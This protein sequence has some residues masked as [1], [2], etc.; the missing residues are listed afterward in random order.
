MARQQIDVSPEQV[1]EASRSFVAPSELSGSR[2]RD[3]QLSVGGRF[4]YAV[5]LLLFAGAL[6]AAI[7]LSRVSAQQRET[8]QALDRTGVVTTA[9]VTRLWRRDDDSWA[10]YRFET[11]GVEYERRTKMRS[12]RWRALH[13]G[14]PIDVRYLP[15]HPQT[16]VLAGSEPGALP[17]FVPFLLAAML[18]AGG[19]LILWAINCQRRLLSDGRAAAA[20]VTDV[21]T[22]KTSDGGTLRSIRYTFQLLSGAIAKGRSD[23]SRKPPALGSVICV[24]YDPDRPRRSRRYP[25]P[26]VK[27]ARL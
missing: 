13:V 22:H 2:P 12:S 6:A 21:V 23:V 24:V 4:V 20:I 14:S 7:L 18:A 8:R 5:S 16:S 11:G 15:D 26:F 1:I 17:A 19:A 3:V 9:E 25:F 27:T 10:S